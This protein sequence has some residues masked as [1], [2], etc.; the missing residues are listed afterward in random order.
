[1]YIA[2]V[3]R[4]IFGVQEINWIESHSLIVPAN[5]FILESVLGI[6]MHADNLPIFMI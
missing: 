4:K 3:C 6:Y 5:Y 1:M 2:T